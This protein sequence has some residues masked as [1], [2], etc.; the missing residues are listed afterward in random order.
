MIAPVWE[1]MVRLTSLVVGRNARRTVRR[2]ASTGLSSLGDGLIVR[3]EPVLAND[4]TTGA[5]RAGLDG[6]VATVVVRDAVAEID[7]VGGVT[8]VVQ[9][10]VVA[11]HADVATNAGV[12]DGVG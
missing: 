11:R 9:V 5:V 3:C 12:V 6:D 2:V 8:T 4:E 10:I 7:E 1:G